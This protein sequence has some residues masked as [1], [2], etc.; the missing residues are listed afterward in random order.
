MTTA[1]EPALDEMMRDFHSSDGTL[2]SLTISIYTVGY[3]IGPLIIAPV[4]E[5]YGRIWPIRIAYVV[6]LIS[7]IIC[8]SCDNLGLFIGFRAIMGFAGIVFVLLAPA[9][10]PDLMIKE[11]TGFALSMMTMGV[12]LVS[13]IRKTFE[14]NQN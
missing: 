3:C 12:S 4:S 7:L 11:R 10:V 9:M 6:F 8:A 1:F 5:I 14:Q 2:E 13:C